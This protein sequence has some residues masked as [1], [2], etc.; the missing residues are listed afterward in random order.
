MLLTTVN[1]HQIAQ[2]TLK[3]IGD[4]HKLTNHTLKHLKIYPV[5]MVINFQIK[6]T[7]LKVFVLQKDLVI[8]HLI[9]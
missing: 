5:F 2:L 1:L 7:L 8:S 3:I 6:R 9:F 4:K